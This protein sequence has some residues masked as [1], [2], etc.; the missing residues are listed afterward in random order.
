[1][2]TNPFFESCWAVTANNISSA[3]DNKRTE[4]DRLWKD[5]ETVCVAVH[6]N[7]DVKTVVELPVEVTVNENHPDEAT[8][9]DLVSCVND[10]PVC[11]EISI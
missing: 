1:M 11:E 10:K 6:N 2:E 4:L 7:G 9:R 3:F 8:T 5:D